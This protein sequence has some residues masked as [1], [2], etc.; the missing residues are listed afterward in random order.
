[1]TMNQE[2]YIATLSQAEQ[3]TLAVCGI[4]KSEQ[5]KHISVD[6]LYEDMQ[7]AAAY[8]PED[9]YTISRQRLEEIYRAAGQS[10]QRQEAHPESKQAEN[11]MLTNH[12]ESDRALPPLVPRH[13]RRKSGAS[14][15]ADRCDTID[16]S[17]NRQG[18][19][20]KNNAIC[21]THPFRTYFSALV[22]IIMILSLLLF[23]VESARLI[24]GIGTKSEVLISAALAG[25]SLGLFFL[26]TR[27][28]KCPVCNMNIFSL[29][30]YPRN[31]N[32]HYFP[33]LGYTLST[34]LHVVFTFWFRCPACG[35]SQKFFK[36]K[37]R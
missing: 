36:R 1:M 2:N 33:L 5:L 24:I 31:K 8:F 28:T 4:L 10:V 26:Y 35:T 18:V 23:L 7:Q 6:K 14:R 11:A 25:G 29:H 15:P 30:N 21:N 27:K 37:R 32:A 16:L 34:A 13:A 22:H 20:N 19:S 17:A 9:L 3:K 12:S